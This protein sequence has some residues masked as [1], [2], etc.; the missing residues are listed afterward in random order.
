MILRGVQRDR[1]IAEAGPPLPVVALLQRWRS[2]FWLDHACRGLEGWAFEPETVEALL[3][4]LSVVP[5]WESEDSLYGFV[6]SPRAPAFF[7]FI[8][9]DDDLT[10]IDGSWHELL[11]YWMAAELRDKDRIN[12]VAEALG[13]P[14]LGARA[15]QDSESGRWDDLPRT[16]GTDASLFVANHG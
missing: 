14:E 1:A 11:R 15:L 13:I 8:Y 2:T 6:G 9:E 5:L 7:A 4:T 12:E 3:P 10:R 16:N